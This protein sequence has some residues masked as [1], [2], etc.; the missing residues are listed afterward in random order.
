MF[1]INDNTGIK[2][3]NNARL[4]AND[5]ALFSMELSARAVI[6]SV[7]SS[8]K[9]SSAIASEKQP[10]KLSN[11]AFDMSLAGISETTFLNYGTVLVDS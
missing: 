1:I 3:I 4:R 8:P 2:T 5:R 9:T 6:A 11:D 7:A 10:T